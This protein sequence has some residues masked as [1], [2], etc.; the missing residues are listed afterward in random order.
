MQLT[1][2]QYLAQK[3]H[4][5]DGR[6]CRVSAGI[7]YGSFLI[8]LQ[9]DVTVA[10]LVY[11]RKSHIFWMYIWLWLLYNALVDVRH[12]VLTQNSENVDPEP[13][14]RPRAT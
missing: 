7:T 6:T 3:T 13:P 1:E 5:C 9:Q 2:K 12:Q 11:V 8:C 10:R 14:R 4:Y